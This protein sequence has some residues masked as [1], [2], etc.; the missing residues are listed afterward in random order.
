MGT[1]QGLRFWINTEQCSE[2]YV[3]GYPAFEPSRVL[4]LCSIRIV[5]LLFSLYLCGRC[6]VRVVYVSVR[7]VYFQ[8]LW[9][10]FTSFT[11]IFSFEGVNTFSIVPLL[12][13]IEC[14]RLPAAEPLVVW[15]PAG[16]FEWPS[17][18]SFVAKS[19]PNTPL[20]LLTCYLIHFLL[21]HRVGQF[22]M[23]EKAPQVIRTVLRKSGL[24]KFIF[25]TGTIMS[26]SPI[27]VEWMSSRQ[28]SSSTLS[29]IRIHTRDFQRMS[30]S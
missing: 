24:H 1:F 8:S 19:P 21:D 13:T 5:L 23:T 15:A 29:R 2:N 4:F 3:L 16:L 18:R 14:G 9:R 26:L 7:S 20:W 10:R 6:F 30:H 22:R 12:K 28:G 11:P 25:I 27:Q 17:S